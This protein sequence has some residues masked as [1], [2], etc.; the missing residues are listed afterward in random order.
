MKKPSLTICYQFNPWNSSIGGIQTIIR[1]FLKYAPDTFEVRLIGTG[2]IRQKIGKWQDKEFAGKMVKFMPL[3]YLANDDIRGL[4]PTT[5]K[6]TAALWKKTFTSDFFHFHRLEPTLMTQQWQGEKTLFLHNDIRQQMGSQTGKKAIL[7]QYFP[8]AY[9]TLEKNLISQ[10]DQ[11]LSCNSETTQFYRTQYP[12]LAPKIMTI[13]NAVDGNIFYPLTPEKR[14][15]QRQQLAQTLNLPLT[16]QFLLFAGRLHPQ[17]DP[18]LLIRSLKA[19]NDANVHLLIAGE[20]EL[21]PQLKAEINQ[22]QL[23]PQVTLLGPVNPDKL[24]TLQ[25]IASAFVLTS[26]YEGLPMVVL[27]ALSSGTPV[28]TTPCGETPK[29][30]SPNSGL[31]CDSRTPEAI[32]QT[33]RNLLSNPDQY[34]SE[35]CVNTA[36][37]YQ[38]KTVITEVYQQMWTRWQDKLTKN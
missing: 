19:L 20:G 29:L 35:A 16:T 32:A 15:Q 5:I 2:N 34:P 8:N 21:T 3:F 1:S 30:L 25:Q 9:F 27:E 7:W 37:P 38:A 26:V 23:Q 18:L 17:K 22:C 12:T 24:A 36:H 6:Y 31:V 4:I 14:E 28:I 33:W 11:I 10:F 13:K